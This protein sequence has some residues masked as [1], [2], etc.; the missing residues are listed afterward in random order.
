MRSL[1]DVRH[2]L[3][4]SQCRF[5]EPAVFVSRLTSRKRLVRCDEPAAEAY[6]LLDQDTGCRILVSSEKLMNYAARTVSS[7]YLGSPEVV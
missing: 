3:E 5:V 2:N 4:T 1:N 7:P 6:G